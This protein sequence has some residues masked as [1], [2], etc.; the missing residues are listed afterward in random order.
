MCD[1]LLIISISISTTTVG[2]CVLCTCARDR[3]SRRE[4]PRKWVVEDGMRWIAVDWVLVS[5]ATVDSVHGL[6]VGPRWLCFTVGGLEPELGMIRW[7]RPQH[8]AGV[9]WEWEVYCG[10]L[11]GALRT[12]RTLRTLSVVAGD[13]GG[14]GRVCWMRFLYL[15][16]SGLR[17]ES[18]ETPLFIPSSLSLRLV[19]WRV[20]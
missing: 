18:D 15:G 12:L 2:S 9:G 3:H 4:S 14:C 13:R 5:G 8:T 11:H 7:S 19:T 17:G 10:G 20:G 6:S 1:G 16:G